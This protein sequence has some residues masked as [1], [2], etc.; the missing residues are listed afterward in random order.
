[1]AHGTT[2]P[3]ADG[4]WTPVESLEA[5]LERLELDG[6]AT[7]LP[8]IDPGLRP[9][10]YLEFLQTLEIITAFT[11]TLS[12]RERAIFTRV[13]VDQE[14][15]TAVATDLGVSKMAIS[16]AVARLQRKARAFALN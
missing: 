12:G 16:K 7:P 4:F 15:Q 10:E 5:L 11:D 1:M 9:D 2:S 13:M 6:A 14:S 3:V 8:L